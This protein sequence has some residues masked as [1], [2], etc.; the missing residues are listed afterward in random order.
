MGEV[1]AQA[2]P[3]M[4]LASGDNMEADAYVSQLDVKKM[5][6]G[7][8]AEL[9][10]DS[11]D[12]TNIS[13]PAKIVSIYPAETQI[14][15]VPAYKVTLELPEQNAELKLG[16]AG[17]ANIQISQI[18]NAITVPQSS[19]FTSDNKKYVMTLNNG[20]PQ[21]KEVE[22]GIYG[23]DGMVEILSGLAVGDKVITF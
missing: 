13:V 22:T 17:T 9:I 16:M 14:N 18:S 21:S 8:Q 5:A 23:S 19:V 3:V 11:L 2:G 20:I 1:V 7:D 4:T 6:T 12:E 15:G 10:F